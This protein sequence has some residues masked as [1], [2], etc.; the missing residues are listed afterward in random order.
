MRKVSPRLYEALLTLPKFA[1]PLQ[2]NPRRC[3]RVPEPLVITEQLLDGDSACIIF[4]TSE[5]V[6]PVRDP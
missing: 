2:S 5:T 1:A 4:T 6:A 3:C